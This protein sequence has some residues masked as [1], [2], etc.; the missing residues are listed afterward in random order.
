VLGSDAG[1]GVGDLEQRVAP[2]GP[3]ID[4]HAPARRRVLERVVQQDQ[5]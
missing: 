3:D 5:Q 2:V 1:P 4:R